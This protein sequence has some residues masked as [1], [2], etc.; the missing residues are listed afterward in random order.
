MAKR[1]DIVVTYISRQGARRHLIEEH[2]DALASALEEMCNAH[3]WELNIVMAERLTK[4]EQAE[5]MARTTVSVVD[6]SDLSDL[7]ES[8][9]MFCRVVDI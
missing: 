1:Q 7:G 2:H 8:T 4:D 9:V 3:G 5:L 6:V